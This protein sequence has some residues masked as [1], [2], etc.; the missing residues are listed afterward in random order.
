MSVSLSGVQP[1]MFSS[2]DDNKDRKL[3]SLLWTE[4]VL[5]ILETCCMLFCTRLND[6]EALYEYKSVK[7]LHKSLWQKYIDV[8]EY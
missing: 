5:V 2:T 6:V 3:Y 1:Y 4:I 8:R 7:K